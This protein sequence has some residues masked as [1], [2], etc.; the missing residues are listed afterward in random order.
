M[1]K[2]MNIKITAQNKKKKN[3]GRQRYKGKRKMSKLTVLKKKGEYIETRSE[4]Y[5]GGQGIKMI[6]EPKTLIET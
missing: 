4:S 5:F 6:A 3:H 2:A 1:R